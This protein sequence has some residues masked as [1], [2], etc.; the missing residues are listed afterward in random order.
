MGG[1]RG[2]VP[3]LLRWVE[4]CVV[5]R[6]GMEVRLMVGSSSVQAEVLV[7]CFWGLKF[8]ALNPSTSVFISSFFAIS[9]RTQN[10]SPLLERLDT[11]EYYIRFV[12]IVSARSRLCKVMY[13]L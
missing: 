5:D 7:P 3:A 1:K 12:S 9:A 10:Y 6:G 4:V 8:V 2:G 13:E 11:V